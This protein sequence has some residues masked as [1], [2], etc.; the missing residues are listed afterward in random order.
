MK[1]LSNYLHCLSSH[2]NKTAAH[3]FVNFMR[4]A[5]SLVFDPVFRLFSRTMYE[6][7]ATARSQDDSLVLPTATS[8][9]GEYI[10]RDYVLLEAGE[11]EL[12][13]QRIPVGSKNG[14]TIRNTESE[15]DP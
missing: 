11:G 3:V 2:R 15:G 8:K 7:G 9:G 4:V 12:R 5:S 10:N 1:T 13:N 14:R 6:T